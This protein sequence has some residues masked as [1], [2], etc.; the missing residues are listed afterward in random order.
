[1]EAVQVVIIGILATILIVIFKKTIPEFGVY[2]GVATSVVIFFI[3]IDKLGIILDLITR[4]SNLIDIS[5]IY[6]KILLWN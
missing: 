6:I 5:D 3:I 1:M 4:I 2:L